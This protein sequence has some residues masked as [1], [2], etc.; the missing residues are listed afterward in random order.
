MSKFLSALGLVGG[1]YYLNSRNKWVDFDLDLY[2]KFYDAAVSNDVQSNK[3]FLSYN[4]VSLQIIIFNLLYF[5]H[6]AK[7]FS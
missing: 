2:A 7:L 5:S 4:F 3:K 1:A 6:L